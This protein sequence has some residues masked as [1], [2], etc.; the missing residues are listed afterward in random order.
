[1]GT[2]ISSLV[3]S[4][5]AAPSSNTVYV[6]TPQ[7]NTANSTYTVQLEANVP[8]AIVTSGVNDYQ[9]GANSILIP[10][11]DSTSNIDFT[12]KPVYSVTINPQG[13][14][15]TQ[16]SSL[17]LTFTNLNETGYIYNFTSISSISLRNG[18]YSISANG[19]DNYPVQLALTSNLVVNGANVSKTINFNP[20]IVW[21]F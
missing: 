8:Y 16:A 15:S 5:N 9:I 2:S 7:I 6:P 14:T 10:A 3:L 21:S 17:Q 4:F 12:L 18:T 1:M 13:L 19:L 20:V 11:S